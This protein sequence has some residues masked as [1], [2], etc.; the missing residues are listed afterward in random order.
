[1]YDHL[2]NKPDIIVNRFKKAGIKQAIEDPAYEVVPQANDED[3][4]A[5][6]SDCD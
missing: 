2:C 3:P 6:L 5:D 4:F 1:M